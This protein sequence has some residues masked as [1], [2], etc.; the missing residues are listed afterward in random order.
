VLIGMVAGLAILLLSKKTTKE[1]ADL[2][3]LKAW[4]PADAGDHGHPDPRDH[5][6]ASPGPGT[7]SPRLPPPQSAY[8]SH[9]DPLVKHLTPLLCGLCPFSPCRCLGPL[10]VVTRN[11][12]LAPVAPG[13]VPS[14][15]PPP[16]PPQRRAGSLRSVR[17][18]AHA[19][20][21][22]SPAD[23]TPPAYDGGTGN[24]TLPDAPG[25]PGNVSVRTRMQALQARVYVEK[26]VREHDL[27]PLASGT[28]PRPPSRRPGRWAAAPRYPAAKTTGNNVPRARRMP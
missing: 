17:P 19:S 21:G 20:G 15:S 18:P 24:R 4:H 16:L 3:S 13:D 26:P 6:A 12:A 2:H 1:E 28:A 23:A 25:P 8:R 10:D 11:G 9:P 27:D 5:R 7:P 22:P 14:P